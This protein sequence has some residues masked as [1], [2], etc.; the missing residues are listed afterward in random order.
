MI[1]KAPA[2][3]EKTGL[4]AGFFE[5]VFDQPRRRPGILRT[6]NRQGKR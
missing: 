2:F 3:F 5:A 4:S 1:I 6:K